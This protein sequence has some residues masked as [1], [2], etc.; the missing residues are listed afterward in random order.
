MTNTGTS[1]AHQQSTSI[2]QD[3]TTSLSAAPFGSRRHIAIFGA[4]NAG[5]STL[6]NVLLGQEMS[7]VSSQH[8]T[9]TDPVI[10]AMELLDYGPIALIDT[11]GLNDM[12]ELGRQRVK[13]SRQMLGRADAALYVA[14][15]GAWLQDPAVLSDYESLCQ[16]FHKAGIPHKLILAKADNLTSDQIDLI[17]N[18]SKSKDIAN[19]PPVLISLIQEGAA[20]L[21]YPVLAD[22]L[23][24]ADTLLDA[25]RHDSAGYT[26]SSNSES[27]IDGLVDTG[28]TILL[29]VPVD[30][31]AP[32]GRLILPQV[33]LIRDC[34]DHGIKCLV[35]RDHE[36]ARTIEEYGDKLSLAVTDSQAFALAAALV[37]EKIPLT[38]FSMLLAAQ[39]GDFP[40]MISGLRQIKNLKDGS[41]VLISEACSHNTSHEDIGKIKIPALLQ[42]IT[43]AKLKFE[44]SAGQSYPEELERFS[45]IVHCGG[46]MLTHRT[47]LA[48]IRYAADQQIA[49]TNYG[50]LLAYGNGIIHRST[51]IFRQ[52]RQLDAAFTEGL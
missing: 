18:S 19:E 15:A 13:R 22:L 20:N 50:L 35:C 31:E 45:M 26:A 44:F 43:G 37:P 38:S 42:K 39:K 34:L 10:K 48:R 21:L 36:L 14:D 27:V 41:T 28:D 6:F 8:G 4:T 12:T 11:A 16:E 24:R 49:I 47:M 51:E 46:C 33:Q 32:K 1:P 52:R 17:D 25:S 29:I 3:L 30:S 5:K 2:R 9:T 7:I 40:L 23:K